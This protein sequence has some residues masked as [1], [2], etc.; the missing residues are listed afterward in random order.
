VEHVGRTS[1]GVGPTAC[2]STRRRVACLGQGVDHVPGGICVGEQ[3]GRH[4]HQQNSDIPLQ[5]DTE[6]SLRL[7]LSHLCCYLVVI[8]VLYYKHYYRI[9]QYIVLSYG[10]NDINMVYLKT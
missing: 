1:G 8:D 3:Q 2:G 9:C 10:V 5:F 4:E 6:L 7:H